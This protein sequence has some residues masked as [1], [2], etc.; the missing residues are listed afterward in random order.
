MTYI[1]GARCSDGVVLIG[2]T[3]V[4][5]DSGADYAYSKKITIPLGNVVMGSAGILGTIQRD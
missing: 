2:D 3:K 1:V 5:I 4:T